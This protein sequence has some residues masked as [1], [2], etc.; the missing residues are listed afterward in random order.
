MW[1]TWEVVQFLK[2]HQQSLPH[3]IGHYNVYYSSNFAHLSDFNAISVSVVCLRN[4]KPIDSQ[5][6]M[7]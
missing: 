6:T 2:V 4:W 3:E 5:I 7:T 1:E